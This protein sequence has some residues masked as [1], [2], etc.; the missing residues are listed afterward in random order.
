MTEQE[1]IDTTNLVK[2]T[3]AKTIIRDVLFMEDEGI[4]EKEV[5]RII[6]ALC[7][8]EAALRL[9]VAIDPVKE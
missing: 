1:Y 5:D 3:A 7:R 6:K 4:N 9:V 2:I 8:I